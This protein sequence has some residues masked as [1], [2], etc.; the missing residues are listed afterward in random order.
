MAIKLT[1]K[2]EK[3]VQEVIRTGN[4]RQAYK[5]AYPNTRMSEASVDSEP[6]AMLNGTGKYAKNPKVSKRY[7]ELL[8]EA[9]KI[10]E[11]QQRKNI[12]T[13][14]D[15][16]ELLSEIAKKKTAEDS[17]RIRAIDVLNR[18]NADYTDKVNIEGSVPIVLTGYDDVED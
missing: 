12:L 13:R 7:H 17:D 9:E 16:E 6:S 11:E 8:A 2:Q 14:L 15:R 1:M 10:K 5:T 3:F 18:M 4:Q